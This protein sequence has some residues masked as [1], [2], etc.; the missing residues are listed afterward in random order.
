MLA[1]R[2]P[3]VK[4]ARAAKKPLVRASQRPIVKQDQGSSYVRFEIGNYQFLDDMTVQRES[5]QTQNEEEAAMNLNARFSLK[6]LTLF[7]SIAYLFT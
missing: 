7:A 1:A 3:S 2:N 4:A 6:M 5:T